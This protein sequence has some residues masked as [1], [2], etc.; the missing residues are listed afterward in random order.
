MYVTLQ[1]GFDI[2]ADALDLTAHFVM[3]GYTC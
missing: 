2:S 1:S 3:S